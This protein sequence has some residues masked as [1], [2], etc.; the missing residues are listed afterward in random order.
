MIEKQKNLPQ[1][2]QSNNCVRKERNTENTEKQNRNSV[3]S[4]VK[5]SGV[6]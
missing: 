3:L 5:E 6:E 1:R 2:T 4:A